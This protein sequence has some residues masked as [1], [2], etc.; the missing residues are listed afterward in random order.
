MK[1][2]YQKGYSEGYKK[3]LAEA[4]RIIAEDV[5]SVMGATF[6]YLWKV[7]GYRQNGIQKANKY[8]LDL[9]NDV[10]HAN[11]GMP[12]LMEEITGLSIKQMEGHE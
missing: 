6:I 11:Y 12:E 8:I 1:N 10:A 9:W 7:H 4:K 2:S 3:G 5:E